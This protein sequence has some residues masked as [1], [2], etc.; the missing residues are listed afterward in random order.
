MSS[1]G[2]A[3]NGHYTSDM[4]AKRKRWQAFLKASKTVE[5]RTNRYATARVTRIFTH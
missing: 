3:P 5:K 4:G 1:F 2:N